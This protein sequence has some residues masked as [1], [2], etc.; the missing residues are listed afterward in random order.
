MSLIWSQHIAAIARAAA[1]GDEAQLA[2]LTRRHP[3]AARALAPLLAAVAPRGPAAVALHALEQQA[4]VLNAAGQL[5]REQAALDKSAQESRDSVGRLTDGSAGISTALAQVAAALGNAGQASHASGASISELDGQLRLLRSA[6]SAMNR[7]QSRLAERVEQIRK[8]TGAVQEIAHQTN[9]VALNAAIEAARAG[10]AGRG[11]AV[12][13]DEVKQLAEKT[14]QTT[15]E[16][17]TVTGSIGDFSLQLDG[18]VQQ[19]LRRLE[20]AQAGL[21]QAGAT[22]RDSEGA[23]R[24]ASERVAVLQRSQDAQHARATGAQAAL[25]A[26]QRRGTEARR[27]AEAM[28]RAA[29]LA[30]RLALDWLDHHSGDD[31]ASLSLAVRE[32]AQGIRQAMELALQEPSSLDRRWFDTGALRRTLA[33]LTARHA[34]H[35]AAAALDAAGARLDEQGSAFVGLLC[36]GKLDQ[37]AQV[38]QQLEAEREALIS[39][40]AAL[41][42]DATD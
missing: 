4:L 2:A 10:E 24:L 38:S 18:D 42:A 13:A 37:A 26:L 16:I 9:L 11:F 17:E 20:R 36:E 22:Q 25:G 3:A 1:A 30:H 23:V 41:L 15:T 29:L 21:D 34:G 19:G 8:L 28:H 31:T 40:L 7:N 5:A 27:Q 32:S 6:L 33:R 39:Q 35:P 14:A 12:V